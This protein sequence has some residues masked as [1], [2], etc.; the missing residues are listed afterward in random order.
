MN[1]IFAMLFPSFIALKIFSYLNQNKLKTSD[2]VIFYFIFNVITNL[3]LYIITIYIFNDDIIIFTD[4]YT[5]KYLI[6]SI[7][8][9]VLS[10]IMMSMLLKRLNIKI[11]TK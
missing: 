3:I 6:L 8:L 1:Q 2:L 5:I 10:P 7:I 4:I 11:Q 9:S